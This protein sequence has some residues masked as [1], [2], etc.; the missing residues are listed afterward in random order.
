MPSTSFYLQFL[1]KKMKI[2]KAYIEKPGRLLWQ[3]HHREIRR[4]KS[5]WAKESLSIE[6]DMGNK[7]LLELSDIKKTFGNDPGQRGMENLVYSLHDI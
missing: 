7:I 3:V 6:Q 2:T 4:R 5:T 1:E